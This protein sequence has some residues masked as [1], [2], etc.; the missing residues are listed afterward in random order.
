[1]RRKYHMQN[2]HVRS[3]PRLGIVP[4]STRVFQCLLMAGHI[5]VT[6]IRFWPRGAG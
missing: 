5:N 6:A 4:A 2:K 3:D 1:M